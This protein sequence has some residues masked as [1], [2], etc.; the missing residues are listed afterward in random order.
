VIL[1]FRAQT[2]RLPQIATLTTDKLLLQSI[3]S[4]LLQA[5]NVDVSLVPDSF[6]EH[7]VSQ[8]NPVCAVLG[9]VMAAEIIKAVSQQDAPINNFFLY[10]GL[11]GFGR[12]Y[13][14][15]S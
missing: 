7:C 6:T 3:R 8:F 5:M 2:G 10:N 11:D 14:L 1:E 15:G 4:D 13:L 9:G 12:V